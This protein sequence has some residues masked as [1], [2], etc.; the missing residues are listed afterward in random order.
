MGPDVVL[1]FHD[2]DEYSSEMDKRPATPFRVGFLLIDGFALMS[3]AS[4]CEPLR[5]ANVLAGRKL[6]D[7]SHVCITGDKATSSGGASVPAVPVSEA[8]TGFDLV[9]A[10]ASG[11]PM[12]F[13]DRRAFDWL[14]RCDRHGT[15][16]GGVSGGPVLLAR[17]GLL[18]D[19]RM[20]VHWEHMSPLGELDPSLMME[21]SLYVIDRDR[22]TCSGG[23][24]PLD[25]MHALI[26]EHHGAGFAREVSDWFIHTEIRP[27][28]GPQRAG[29][30]ERYG[31]TDATVLAAIEAMINRLADPLSLPALAALAGVGERQL[32]RLFRDKVGRSTMAFYRMLRLDKA[33][34]LLTQTPL[35]LTEIALATGFSSSAHFSKAFREA[36][37]APP[38]SLRK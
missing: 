5:A 26:A 10:V 24:A 34:N 7:V 16:L 30:V 29:L 32:N 14:R 9:L 25:M 33:R 4:C 6:Y 8:G 2:P 3:Y 38:S 17:A 20:T 12:G 27:P 18:A 1:D 36:F 21:R 37:A 35:S 19:R 31:T 28:G 23:S 13:S 22:Y 11:D 15:P